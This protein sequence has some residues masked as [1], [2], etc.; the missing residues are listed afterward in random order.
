M[1]WMALSFLIVLLAGCEHLPVGDFGTMQDPNQAGMVTAQ[2]RHG[3]TFL[4]WNEV[5]KPGI[6]YNIYRSRLPIET[7]E[8]L[9]KDNLLATVNDQTSLN[10]MASINRTRFNSLPP[11]QPYSL[12]NRIYYVIEDGMAP[13]ADTTGLFVYTVQKFGQAFYAVTAV[14]NGV[15]NRNLYALSDGNVTRKAVHERIQ[16]VRPV[17]Q[18][19]TDYVHWTDDTGTRHYPAMSSVPGLA[20]N[21]RVH[22]PAV[23]G[24]YPVIGVL[25]AENLQFNTEDRARYAKVDGPEGDSAI[26]VALDSPVIQAKDA[27][28]QP[29]QIQGLG[30][31]AEWP[32]EGWYG[33]NNHFFTGKPLEQGKDED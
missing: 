7:P 32:F 23:Q 12:E 5:A 27:N 31:V 24:Q 29:R 2:F 33:Y 6:K 10:L 21:F 13:L 15:E 22:A 1:R 17:K 11:G 26:R 25:H 16:A 18:N 8:D 9:S 20:Y 19:A 14:E 3:Q 4:T 28:G 30:P